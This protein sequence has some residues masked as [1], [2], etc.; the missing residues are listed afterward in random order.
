MDI[1]ILRYFLAV[2]R[3][4]NITKAANFLHIS[5]PSLSVQLMEL[6]QELGKKLLVRGKRKITLTDEGVLL[7]KRAE[8]IITLVEKT[9]QEIITDTET[10]GGDISIGSGETEAMNVAVKI[11]AGLAEEYPGIHYQLFS[12]DAEAI[13]E[14]L[15]NGLLDFGILIEPVDITKYER[16]HLN[17]T[18]V[19]GM[20]IRV[21][22]PLA[23]KSGIEPKD[24]HDI[25]IIAPRRPEL[26]REFSSWMRKDLQNL[27]IV[28]TYNLIYNASL[29]VREGFGYAIALNKLVYTGKDSEL[30]FRPF[31]PKMEVKLSI[32]W[33]KYQVFSKASEKFI[34]VLSDSVS[35]NI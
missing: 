11:A 5:Q 17:V 27:N 2:A 12:G 35:K 29:L 13:M 9:E 24:I 28:A 16:I 22:S 23:S 14:Q 31:V 6:E 30:C 18:D 20:L 34:E 10:I 8:E 26:Q 25:P 32:V 7:R 15:D 33:K 1:R 19:W 3:E 21:D 4:E